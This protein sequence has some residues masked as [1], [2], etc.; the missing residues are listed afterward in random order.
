[1]ADVN[2]YPTN[3]IDE[4]NSISREQYDS[5]W[6]DCLR[7]EARISE[8]E[9]QLSEITENFSGIVNVNDFKYRLRLDNLLTSELDEAIDAYLKFYNNAF[10]K[11]LTLYDD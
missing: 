8:L 2:I 1:M 4:S 5:L 3:N 9:D 11:E 10:L 6:Q 7:C